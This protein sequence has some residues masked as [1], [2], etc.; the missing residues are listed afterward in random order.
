MF[1]FWSP[2]HLLLVDEPAWLHRNLVRVI[3]TWQPQCRYSIPDS[4]FGWGSSISA[5]WAQYPSFRRSLQP[6]QCQP[7][8]GQLSCAIVVLAEPLRL[9]FWRRCGLV[10]NWHIASLMSVRWRCPC[11]CSTRRSGG[12]PLERP[13]AGNCGRRGAWTTFTTTEDIL[14]ILMQRYSRYRGT[15]VTFVRLNTIWVRTMAPSTGLNKLAVA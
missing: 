11:R 15:V 9:C 7:Q 12:S 4:A 8:Y 2:L 5:Q 6:W 14:R 10:F 3:P 13:G 1:Q